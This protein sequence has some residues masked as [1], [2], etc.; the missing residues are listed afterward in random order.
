M[1][2]ERPV[3]LPAASMSVTG[4]SLARGILQKTAQHN[5]LTGFMAPHRVIARLRPLSRSEL[6][7]RRQPSA[8]AMDARTLALA[9]CGDKPA[10][11]MACDRVIAPSEVPLRLALTSCIVGLHDNRTLPVRA[12]LWAQILTELQ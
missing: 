1:K 3:I 12:C 5:S 9:A 8:R 10:Q 6:A 2:P 11:T 4:Y 7:Q